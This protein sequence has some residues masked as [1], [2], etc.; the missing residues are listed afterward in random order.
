MDDQT[1]LDQTNDRFLRHNFE[2][3]VVGRK[4]FN[5]RK[6]DDKDEAYE[7]HSLIPRIREKPLSS[8]KVVNETWYDVSAT[9]KRQLEVKHT[10][11]MAKKPK[12][13]DYHEGSV[14]EHD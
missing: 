1:P 12:R 6:F 11:R 9:R 13:D 7:P 4:L 8:P 14:S 2:Y 5:T 3:K 10:K